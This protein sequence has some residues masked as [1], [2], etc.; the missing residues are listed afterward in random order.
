MIRYPL[1]FGLC[2]FCLTTFAQNSVLEEI[3]Q[4]SNE[5]RPQVWWHWMNGNISQ[6]G[7][8][9]DLLWMH[10]IGIAPSSADIPYGT[11]SFLHVNYAAFPIHDALPP[12][13]DYISLTPFHLKQQL[14]S[15]AK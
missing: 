2:F 4:R 1:L 8:R 5:A 11:K 14:P 7:I 10:R 13:V 3:D 9:K 12:D 15:S 6:D